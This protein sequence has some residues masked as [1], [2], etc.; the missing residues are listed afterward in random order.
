MQTHKTPCIFPRK[1]IIG[2]CALCFIF[3]VIHTESWGNILGIP[4]AYADHNCEWWDV[5]CHV[6]NWWTHNVWDFIVNFAFSFVFTLAWIIVAALWLPLIVIPRLVYW[7]LYELVVGVS[8]LCIMLSTKLIESAVY[9][10]EALAQG[11]LYNPNVLNAIYTTLWLP[12]RDLVHVGFALLLITGAIITIVKADKEIIS[13]YGSK[14]MIAIILVNFSWFI[15]RVVLDV[16]NV[17]AVASFSFARCD[18]CYTIDNIYLIP[19]TCTEN[20]AANPRLV[21]PTLLLTIEEIRVQNVTN[22]VRKA[23]GALLD[24]F[25]EILNLRVLPRTGNGWERL[26]KLF[27]FYNRIGTNTDGEVPANPGYPSGWIGIGNIFQCIWGECT[28]PPNPIVGRINGIP[29]FL[30]TVGQFLMGAVLGSFRMIIL[31]FLSAIFLVLYVFALVALMAMVLLR[32]PIIWLTLGFM[33]VVALAFVLGKGGKF[34]GF[35]WAVWD[36]FVGAAFIPA[37]IGIPIAAG[38]AILNTARQ[39]GGNPIGAT[40]I[41]ADLFGPDGIIQIMFIIIAIIVIW[42]GVFAAINTLEF[43]GDAQ[44]SLGNSIK[45]IGQG[46]AAATG[47]KLASTMPILPLGKADRGLG[48]AIGGMTAGAGLL[49]QGKGIG[50]VRPTLQKLGIITKIPPPTPGTGTK[51]GPKGTGGTPP[52]PKPTPGTGTT[53]ATTPQVAASMNAL[54]TPAHTAKLS[55]EGWLQQIQNETNPSNLRTLFDSIRGKLQ[56]QNLKVDT[57]NELL[58][59]LTNL[60]EDLLTPINYDPKTVK[61]KMEQATYRLSTEGRPTQAEQPPTDTK[62]QPEIYRFADERPTQTTKEQE[63]IPPAENV[64]TTEERP[65]IAE[66]KKGIG[67]EVRKGAKE[68]VIEGMGGKA[69][70]ETGTPAPEE[71]T[72]GEKGKPAT[73]GMGWRAKLAS[74]GGKLQGQGE[75]VIQRG[76]VGHVAATGKEWWDH[77]KSTNMGKRTSAIASGTRNLIGNLFSGSALQKGLAGFAMKAGTGQLNTVLEDYARG[78]GDRSL[79]EILKA[80]LRPQA[81]RDTMGKAADALDERKATAFLDATNKLGT[82]DEQAALNDIRTLLTNIARDKSLNIDT[83]RGLPGTVKT[84]IDTVMDNPSHRLHSTFR[85]RLGGKSG[86]SLEKDIIEALGR[87][88]PPP[89]PQS[90]TPAPS[91]PPATPPTTH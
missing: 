28:N 54:G 16:A 27:V 69:T 17:A 19:F 82:K 83:D 91:T 50:W 34:S 81:S 31:I 66:E 39:I 53:P 76:A 80:R 59:T 12:V 85:N 52:P 57:D 29:S 44:K 89:A 43:A 73:E 25:M 35:L 6:D 71:G 21:C 26:N 48:F 33:P 38:S 9:P 65:A 36:K 22:P 4:T 15:P 10:G 18:N 20:L 90:T 13:Q 74:I 23:M 86:L 77:L 63:K 51:P 72:E 88:N 75:K 84:L 67:E 14:F 68:G 61:E 45:T 55:M 70:E 42:L 37:A 30:G 62:A 49:M 47:Y 1:S 60:N 5:F 87:T 24:P 11:L 79:G 78:G 46:A 56:Q 41:V 64:A 32:I 7:I 8:S 2:A 40:G 3:F 58:S